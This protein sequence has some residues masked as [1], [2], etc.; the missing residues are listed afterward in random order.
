MSK[1]YNG[2]I[3][4]SSLFTGKHEK[5]TSTMRFIQ[6]REWFGFFPTVFPV[7]NMYEQYFAAL[8]VTT[9][10]VCAAVSGILKCID[11]LELNKLEFA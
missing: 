4:L 9:G 6:I 2:V 7:L 8:P 11:N 3:P 10:W 5:G 1:S